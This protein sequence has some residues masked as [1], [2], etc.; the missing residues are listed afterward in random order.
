MEKNIKMILSKFVY[1][2]N[3]VQFIIFNLITKLSFERKNNI[4]F[5]VTLT[6]M[7]I[8]IYKTLNKMQK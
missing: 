2:Y 8:H 1:Q 7:E 6:T 5:Y 4:L 3:K